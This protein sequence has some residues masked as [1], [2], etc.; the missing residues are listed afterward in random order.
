MSRYN[1][2]SQKVLTFTNL[3]SKGF[4]STNFKY[5]LRPVFAVSKCFNGDGYRDNFLLAS[6]TGP[7]DSRNC[8][9]QNFSETNRKAP[10]SNSLICFRNCKTQ[11]PQLPTER[12]L[13]VLL[14]SAFLRGKCSTELELILFKCLQIL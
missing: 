3:D 9:N 12:I 11:T 7:F 1:W 4:Y 14:T 8:T 13:V 10:V 5:D 2:H 6:F